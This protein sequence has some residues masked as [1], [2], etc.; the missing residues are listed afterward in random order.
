[1]S[2]GELPR[3]I[4]PYPEATLRDLARDGVDAGITAIPVVGGPLQIL[5]DAVITLSC[6]GE[7]PTHE[8]ATQ[9]FFMS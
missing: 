9:W 1:M 5:F 4:E 6:C 3:E 8:N 2:D 7:R